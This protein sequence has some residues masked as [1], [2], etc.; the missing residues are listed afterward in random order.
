MTHAAPGTPLPFEA[1][2]NFRELGG[3]QGLGGK[4]VKYGVFYRT[5]ALANLHTPADL[6]RFASLGVRT[7]FD[8]RS[9]PEKEQMPDPVFPGIRR[10]EAP[11]MLDA[12]G[13]NVNF[14]LKSVFSSGE[15]GI[16]E[17]LT[18]V[19]ESYRNMPFGNPAYR[20]LFAAIAADETPVLFHCTAG[21]DRTGVAAALILLS[22]GVP[23]EDA[24][25]DYLITNECRARS[26][27]SL[28]AQLEPVLGAER[29]NY[30]AG[31]IGGV[32]RESIEASLGAIEAR[33]PNFETYLSAECGVTSEMLAHI[34]A[35][36]LE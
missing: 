17:M 4:H 18:W 5:P 10:V 26:R 28:A 3:Y 27:A 7:I 22:L 2:D 16:D 25:R 36:Y 30:Y 14:D 31:V 15:R 11:A 32:R 1:C 35:Q 21:K 12:S 24:I 23:R 6:E 19:E 9:D 33:Y 29:A 20:S 13:S 8:F 34:R